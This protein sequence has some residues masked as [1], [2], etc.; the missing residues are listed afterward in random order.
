MELAA[1]YQDL[2]RRRNDMLHARPATVDGR[3]RLSRWDKRRRRFGPLT[4]DALAA[5]LA[6]AEKL[7][8]D[9]DVIPGHVV[10]Q[11][12]HRSPAGE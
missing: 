10:D 7:S 9:L 2:V 11:D 8:R 1:R 4:D 5:F 12:R 6:D 3:Q